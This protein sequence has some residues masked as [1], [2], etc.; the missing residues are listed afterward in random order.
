MQDF[1]IKLIHETK[2]ITIKKTIFSFTCF[3]KKCICILLLVQCSTFS[4]KESCSPKTLHII[5]Y[6]GE[7]SHIQSL[8]NIDKHIK[9]TSRDRIVDVMFLNKYDYRAFIDTYYGTVT[10]FSL[11]DKHKERGRKVTPLN[12]WPEGCMSPG[13]QISTLQL[14]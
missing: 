4:K 11:A 14:N 12:G 5:L 13:A 10:W 7:K 9:Q 8:D 2:M 1:P 6:S 3:F